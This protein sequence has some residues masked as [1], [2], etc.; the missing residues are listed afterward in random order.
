MV[1]PEALAMLRIARRDLQAAQLL[2]DKEIDEAIWG[3][4][5]Q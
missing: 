2:Q 1:K 4:Q 3:F 5:I